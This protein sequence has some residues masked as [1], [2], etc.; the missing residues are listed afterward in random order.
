M[1]IAQILTELEMIVRKNPMVNTVSYE[2]EFEIDFNKTNIYPLVN[3]DLK[4]SIPNTNTT[5][6]IIETTILQ[7]RDSKP[8]LNQDNKRFG[9][10]KVD[11][12][13][14]THA[15]AHDLLVKLRTNQEIDLFQDSEILYLNK[16][17]INILDGVVFTLYIEVESDTYC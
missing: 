12:W 8:K 16:E 6:Y 17:Y 7:Q 11:N 10:N 5:R 4:R 9:D 2:N 3:F 14:E 13:N 15:M 1:N